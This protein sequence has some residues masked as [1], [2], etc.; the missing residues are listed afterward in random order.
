[1]TQQLEL[2]ARTQAN[3]SA[4][5]STLEAYI[6]ISTLEFT[7]LNRKLETSLNIIDSCTKLWT[8]NYH[9]M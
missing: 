6:I 1:M 9:E 8:Q 2:P 3:K 7:E 4:L 5:D